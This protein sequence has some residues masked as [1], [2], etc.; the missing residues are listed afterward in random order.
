MYF[1]PVSNPPQPLLDF[2]LE[3]EKLRPNLKCHDCGA[4]PGEPH[5]GGCDTARC[6]S[7]GGQRL[8][9]D[10]GDCGQDIWTGLWPGIIEAYKWGHV[11][12]DTHTHELRFDLNRTVERI[13]RERS[14]DVSHRR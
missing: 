7:T 3:Q 9:C 10:C 5:T 11:C 1:E 13:M 12:L 2:L 8:C 14:K 6:L 4:M